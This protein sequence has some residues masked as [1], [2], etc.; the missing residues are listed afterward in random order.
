MPK[1]SPHL[2]SALQGVYICSIT[3][4][5][6][7][8]LTDLLLSLYICFLNSS[9]FIRYL[10]VGRPWAQIQGFLSLYKWS[11]ISRYLERSSSL[12]II[13]AV[14]QALKARTACI[15]AGITCSNNYWCVLRWDFNLGSASKFRKAVTKL[16]K[17]LS[18]N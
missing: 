2:K 14:L 15:L 4:S 17:S 13:T 6:G 3:K 10:I 7:G 18:S 12:P 11:T 1:L 9:R 8:D 5:L 16:W